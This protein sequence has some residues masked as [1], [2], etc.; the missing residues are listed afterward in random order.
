MLLGK[1]RQKIELLRND[2]EL[3][4]IFLLHILLIGLHIYE[5]YVGT[6]EYHWYLRAG[7]C[8]VISLMIFLFGRK[9][10]SYG[11]VVFACA[12]VYINNFYNYATIFFMLIAIG[13][14]PKIKKFAP[15]I[16][17]LNVVV[18]YTI[19]RLGIIP[20]LIHCTYITMFYTKINYVFKVHTPDKLNLTEDER[21]ILDEL[22]AGKLQK[23]IEL[24][25]QQTI[26]QKIKN[27]R[28]RNLCETTSEL[29]SMYL[30]EKGVKVGK[31]GK[32]CKQDCPKREACQ[33]D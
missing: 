17:L 30:T 25:S 16:Y 14:N 32:V 29:I 33:K 9:G 7:G 11:L 21:K 6:I 5:N 8:A 20:F 10:L 3:A 19:K 26:S 13:A 18:A 23:E 24:F 22:A 28:E 15:W 1:L 2:K 4:K 12:L 31:C 27:A